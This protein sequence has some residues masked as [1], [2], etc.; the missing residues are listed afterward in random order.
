MP[1]TMGAFALALGCM[2]ARKFPGRTWYR[3]SVARPVAVTPRGNTARDP[4]RS[5]AWPGSKA[6]ASPKILALSA[7]AIVRTET[8]VQYCG[9]ARGRHSRVRR[10]FVCGRSFGPK[11]PGVC[12]CAQRRASAHL[13]SAK[14]RRHLAGREAVLGEHVAEGDA[15]RQP[16][17]RARRACCESSS[18]CH[19]RISANALFHRGKF[20]ERPP[21]IHAG[22]SAATTS[23]VIGSRHFLFD[24]FELAPTCYQRVCH[25]RDVCAR[26]GHLNLS[27]NH[28]CSESLYISLL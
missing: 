15:A 11:K 17:R 27:R 1:P 2:W 10:S 7:K 14:G 26:A 24:P 16:D 25:C 4:T 6:C 21:L 19:G 23:A 18:R 5:P 22:V 9:F 12:V 3:A 8:F 20:M 28:L 13:V